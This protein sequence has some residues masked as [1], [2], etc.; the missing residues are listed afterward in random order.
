[1]QSEAGI[2]IPSDGEQGKAS[3]TNYVRERIAGLE[4]INTERPGLRSRYPGYDEWIRMKQPERSAGLGT[5]PLNTGRLFWKNNGELETDIANFKEALKE[6]RFAEAF[7]PAV[8]V[9]QVMFMVPTK[10]YSSEREY[11]YALADVLKEEYKA[12][13]D[14]GFVLQIDSP[15]FVMMKL[16]QHWDSTLEEYRK[17]LELRIEAVNHALVGLPMDRIRFHVCWGNYEGPHDTDV[18][19]KDVIDLLLKIKAQAYSIEAANPRH[20]HEWRIWEEVKLPEGKILIPGVIDTV[21]SFIEHPEL[22]AE[23]I[24]RY[25]KLV[26]R[27]NVI[28]AP[29]CGFGTF[30]GWEPRVHPELMWAKFRAMVEGARIATRQLWGKASAG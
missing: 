1:M 28:A 16:R 29:D 3:F 9:G 27:E 19:L 25:A 6:F 24:V 23:R 30:G 4:G 10:Y 18:P 8:A 13:I 17:S 2:D 5:M 26:G 7:M 15:D 14:A 12:I 20:A 21:T 22:V 11:A